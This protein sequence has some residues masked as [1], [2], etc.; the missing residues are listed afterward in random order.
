MIPISFFQLE[1]FRD[2]IPEGKNFNICDIGRDIFQYVTPAGW[3]LHL[4]SLF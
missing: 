2:V 1:H 3:L 4:L